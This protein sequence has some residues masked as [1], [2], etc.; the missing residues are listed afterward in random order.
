MGTL[1]AVALGGAFG[2]L[3]RYGLI[4]ACEQYL[5][6]NFPYGIF[7]AN[8][9]GSFAIGICFVLVVEKGLLPEIGRPLLMI[10]FL[11]AFTTFSTFSLH[12]IELLHA[13]RLS[14]AAVYTLGSVFLSIAAAYASIWMTRELTS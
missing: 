1:I 9:L 6:E 5:G 12:T 14:M 13:G 4:I 7:I 10:G 11:G 3:A 8:I 2:S